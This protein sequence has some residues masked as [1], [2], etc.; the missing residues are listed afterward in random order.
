MPWILFFNTF[1]K[2]K[3]KAFIIISK[4]TTNLLTQQ[5]YLCAV[6]DISKYFMIISYK[7]K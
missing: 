5:R 7:V 2:V 1:E 4:L 3:R 6:Y